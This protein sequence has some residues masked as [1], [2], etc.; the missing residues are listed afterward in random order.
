MISTEM[1]E[2]I[3]ACAREF[4]VK[5][6]WIFGSS[7]EDDPLARDIDLAVEGIPPE[8]FFK[9][10]ARLFMALPKPVD[11]VDLSQDTP[12]ASIVR[13]KGVSIYER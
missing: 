9:F 5:A 11:L 2:T 12:I 8:M 13:A 4:D 6:V 10:Y 1:E 7:L 3:R